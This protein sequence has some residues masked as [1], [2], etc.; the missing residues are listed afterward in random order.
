MVSFGGS[1]TAVQL[2]THFSMNFGHILI[3]RMFGANLLGMYRQGVQLVLGPISQLIYPVYTVSEVTLSR[4]QNQPDSYRRFYH[5]ILMLLCSATMPIAAFV[6]VQAENIVLIMLGPD[7][8]DATPFFRILA[9]AAFLTPANSTINVVMVT[10]GQARKYLWLGLAS[11]GALIV[12]SLIGVTWGA[13]G[14]AAAHIVTTFGLLLPRMYWAFRDTPVTM[15]T[16][17]SAIA[18]PCL[19][20]VLMAVTLQFVGYREYVTAPLASLLLACVI[21]A[22]VYTAAWVAMPGG[23]AELRGLIGNLNDSLRPG[24][25]TREQPA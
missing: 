6:I 4:L 2:A 20:S 22:V 18:R 16:F 9:F 24:K 7:W 10:C 23:R 13:I 5:K 21:G 17:F 1:V 14:V 25:N 8:L 15:G 19:A 3:G 11:T 12:C